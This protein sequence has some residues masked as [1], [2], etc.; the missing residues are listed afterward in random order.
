MK[1]SDSFV[2]L[3]YYIVLIFLDAFFGALIF[4][5]TKIDNINH[6]LN[7]II[8]STFTIVRAIRERDS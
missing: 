4:G 5:D 8:A 6:I 3:T 1:I 2:F 7:L